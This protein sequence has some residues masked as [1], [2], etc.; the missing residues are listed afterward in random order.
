MRHEASLKIFLHPISIALSHIE[1]LDINSRVEPRRTFHLFTAV[2]YV[3]KLPRIRRSAWAGE[4][5]TRVSP[6]TGSSSTQS[7]LKRN[8]PHC[9]YAL[10]CSGT[11]DRRGKT[12]RNLSLSR[13]CLKCAFVYSAFLVARKKIEK[14]FFY[15][16]RLSGGWS[17]SHSRKKL[18][19]NWRIN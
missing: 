10:K 2:L 1:L 13:E 15:I 17:W 12:P 9:F 11:D 8:H 18:I 6:Y 19:F 5:Q 4:L 3:F 7:R 14:F 16:F